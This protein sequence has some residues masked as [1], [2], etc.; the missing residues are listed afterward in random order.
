VVPSPAGYVLRTSSLE[1]PQIPLADIEVVLYGNPAERDAST[2]PPVA[3]FTNPS[4]C[5]GEP[6]VSAVHV[7]SWQ[8]PGSYN[9]D[10]TPDLSDPAW[11][12]A[13]SQSPPVTG[14]DL[15]K[16]TPSLSVQPE[17]STADTPTG[18]GAELKVPQS[19][20]PETLATPPRRDATVTL[21]AG[22]TINPA[23]ASGL[24]VCTEAQIALNSVAP[25]SCPEA[26]KIGSV[27]VSTPLL[28]GTLQGSI[29]LATQNENPFHALLGGY[30]VVNDPTTG[31][32]VK[33]PGAFSLDPA[34]GRI[35][36]VFQNAPQFPVSDLTLHFFGGPRAPVA[37]PEGCGAFTTTSDLMP[38][39]APDSG[40]DATPSS[41]F[42]I[43]SGC[44]RG[45]TPAFTAGSENPQAGDYAPFVLSIS[46]T[47][48]EQDLSGVSVTLPEGALGKIAGIPLCPEANATAGT[49]PEGSVVGSVTAAAGVGPNPYF[50]SGKAYLTGPYDGG[51]FG[52]VEEV[53]AAAGP[54]N[55]GIVVVRQS[56]HV[57][58]VTGQVTAVSNPLPTI[59]DGIPLHVRRVDVV[60]NR[61]GFTFNPTSCAAM[62]VTG[63]LT[64]TEGAS[65]NV[66]SRYQVGGC[67]ELPFK[68]SFTV[69]TRAKGSKQAGA[70]L[71]V[72]VA[73][74]QGQANIA[75]V[76]VSLPIQLPA[77]LTTIQQACPEA[78]YNQNPAS[79]PA[80]SDIGTA[81]AHTPIFAGALIGPAYLV[82][83]GGAAFPN[84]VLILQGEGVTLVL[85]GSINIKHG[86]TSSAFD[87]VPD[88]P[89]S[90]FQLE[91]PQG[92]H[93]GLA[94]NLPAKAKDDFC[95]QNLTMPTTITGHNGAV[96]TQNTKIAVSGCPKLKVKPKKHAKPHK[97][98]KRRGKK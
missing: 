17:T 68:P 54:F 5:D 32:V 29:Y 9:A 58:Q 75:K 19:E 44:T 46:R 94:P 72:N 26:S 25:P 11:V 30:I 16:F 28:S 35:T 6:L 80:G 45:F 59:L 93:S 55:L 74:S 27:E 73:S 10:G 90:S 78:T 79:C 60:L 53:P 91:L 87:A 65:A 18:V 82:S 66:S 15:L 12:T 3:F 76:A 2:N 62:A 4:V 43:E 49:C 48:S 83:H 38:W 63:T 89:V 23:A 7:D 22:M 97:K 61:P 84:L 36:A 8:N 70:S 47:D 92:P 67:S 37:T 64:S 95:G 14:C 42:S 98:T 13:T 51:P 56:L 39:S 69:S 24:A 34:T 77:R 81:T 31:V 40:P 33:I 41:G 86:V 71:T 52:L 21:P 20:E 57:N 1:I 88:A 96:I 50:V 85:S